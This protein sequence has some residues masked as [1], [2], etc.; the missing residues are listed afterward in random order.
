MPVERIAVERITADPEVQSRAHGVNDRV[1]ADY[2]AAMRR[3]D[4]F[5]APDVFRD[6]DRLW[7]A[8][9]FHRLEAMRR[10]G[11]VE[12]DF[13][14]HVGTRSDAVLFSAGA[15]S[16]HGKKRGAADKFRSVQL[17]LADPEWSTRSSK[18]IADHA[19]V[20]WRLVTQIRNGRENEKVR[21]RSGALGNSRKVVTE[22]ALESQE[23]AGKSRR[24]QRF[25]RNLD[26]LS[27][28]C[29][30]APRTLLEAADHIHVE[31]KYVRNLVDAARERGTTIA[32]VS[33]DRKE[34]ALRGQVS[35]LAAAKRRLLEELQVQSAHLDAM[36]ELAT[37]PELPPIVAREGVGEGKRRQGVP[38]MM[39]S[40]LHVEE[41]VTLEKTGG[42]NR[43][44]LEVAEA[45]LDAC[46]DAMDWFEKDP[47]WDFREAIIAILGDTFSGF[48]HEELQQV[49]SLAPVRACAWLLERLE[50]LIR[51]VLA[52]TNFERVRVVCKDG[53]HGRL[54]HKIRAA[55][56]S[57]NSLEWFM[58]FNLAA[59]FRDEPR[60]SFVL[61]DSLYTYVDVFEQTL[62]FTHFDQFRYLGGVG[63]L[64]I[65]VRRG[66]NEIRKYRSGK[67]GNPIVFCGGHFHTRLDDGD[68]VVN[69]SAIGP[70]PY[71]IANSCKPERRAQHFFIVDS[72]HGKLAPTA[73]VWL[74]HTGQ[75]PEDVA[76]REYEERAGFEGGVAP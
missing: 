24:G 61:E 43:Y 20:S 26:L 54:T 55:T 23:R 25:E 74:P 59:R 6:G 22:A 34:H 62:A 18:W 14:V 52:S 35:E 68:I 27:A 31:P 13:E 29:S 66:L 9:G 45:C 4:V 33:D 42:I 53:N 70:T 1:A 56:R 48:I 21:T 63:G 46:A 75:V 30:S 67:G 71:S 8:D 51:R 40:D 41:T 44:D 47:R 17:L 19:R 7:L 64:L 10:A 3:G 36:R 39:L 65:P 15:N 69:G 38:V 28:F 2:T 73:P 32:L 49:N 12:A 5:P 16:A 57:E 72:R 60:V 50:R 11:V 58:Y 76:L 37:L